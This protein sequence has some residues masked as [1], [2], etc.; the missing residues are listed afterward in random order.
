MNGPTKN[1]RYNE[2]LQRWANEGHLAKPECEECD[3]DIFGKNITTDGHR[4]LC[5]DCMDDCIDGCE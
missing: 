2:L 4:W 5:D 1:Q 3:R